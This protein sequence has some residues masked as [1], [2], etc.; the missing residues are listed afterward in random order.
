MENKKKPELRFR[1]FDEE[2]EQKFLGEYGYFYYGKSAPKWS[3][4]EDATI[5]C[6]RY[7]ELYTKYGAKI[8]TI[9]S[10]TNIPK[11]NLKFSSGKEVLVPR[12][13]EDPLD[14]AKCSWLSIPNVAIGEMISVYNTEEDPQF[15]AYYFRSKMRYEF[16]KRVE[17]GNV[18]NLY[19]SYL[20]N[21]PLSIPIKSEQ[22]K[23][24]ILL[25]KIDKTITLNQQ[26]LTTLKQTKQG[27]LQ[28]MFPKEGEKV[29]EVR[30]PGFTDDWEQVRF[31]DFTK[32]SQGLQIAI[33][34]R[35]VEGEKIVFSI[36]QMSF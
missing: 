31:K 6:V 11:E 21:I 24:A 10:H 27:F 2:W 15:F 28:K 22:K 13:G 8:D 30:F 25:E 17:G 32:I 29:P 36:L 16:A 9:Y 12:V 20:E 7:G 35:F 19:Y 5:P 3:V 33:S 26:E 34:D 4:T 14:F 23:I 1:G 18:S